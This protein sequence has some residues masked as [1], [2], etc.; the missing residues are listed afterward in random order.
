MRSVQFYIALSS[1]LLIGPVPLYAQFSE[2]AL[3]VTAPQQAIED[4]RQA[5]DEG[6][7]RQRYPWY[8]SH[9]TDGLQRIEI[10]PPRTSNWNWNLNFSGLK[11]LGWG[12][13]LAM[14]AVMV[15]VLVQAYLNRDASDA[16]S[17]NCS[18]TSLWKWTRTRSS[19]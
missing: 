18:A 16:A 10:E 8:D 7:I 11:V 1:W 5:L 15:L 4:A 2:A 9:Q 17:G 14:L 6:W 19:A 12:V 13:L 3:G